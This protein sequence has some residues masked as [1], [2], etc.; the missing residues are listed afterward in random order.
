[1]ITTIQELWASNASLTTIA[2]IVKKDWRTVKRYITGDPLELCHRQQSSLLDAYVDVVIAFIK[3]GMTQSAI[4][5]KLIKMGYTGTK[6]NARMYARIIAQRYGLTLSKY[7]RNPCKCDENANEK[8]SM[9]YIKRKS[10]FNHLWMNEKLIKSHY[11][12]I[13]EK[14]PVLQT[15]EKCIRQFREIFDSKVMACL[16]IFIDRYKVSQIKELASFAKGLNRDI[17]AIENAVANPLSNGFVEGMNNKLKTIKRSMF[18][19]CRKEL[20]AA[21][22]MLQV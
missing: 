22:L 4:A 9:N 15:L 3:Q 13:W 8:L 7:G 5:S 16:Y 17:K 14:Y 20:L 10:I 12:A 2:S 19:R 18:G 6:T 21:K 11:H 1:M